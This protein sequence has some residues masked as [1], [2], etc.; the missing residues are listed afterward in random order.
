LRR[1]DA[2][3]A[4]DGVNEQF[5]RA[6]KID[7]DTQTRADTSREDVETRSTRSDTPATG[8]AHHR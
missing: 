8:T 4:R 1:S 7:P 5:E 2:N 3:T 6:D